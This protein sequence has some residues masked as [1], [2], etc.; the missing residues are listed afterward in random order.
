MFLRINTSLSASV[1]TK[2]N[3]V[4]SGIFTVYH[5]T[6]SRNYVIYPMPLNETL[7]VNNIAQMI[8]SLSMRKFRIHRCILYLHPEEKGIKERGLSNV[9]GEFQLGLLFQNGDP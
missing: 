3:Q 5:E 1:C 7:S 2:R 8:D 9:S 6:A 4:T